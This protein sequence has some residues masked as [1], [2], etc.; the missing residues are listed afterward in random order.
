MCNTLK[1]RYSWGKLGNQ[2]TNSWYPTYPS[3]GYYP[4]SSGW[5]VGGKKPTYAT[6]PGLIST[7]LTWEKNRTWDIGIDWG[8]FNNRLTGTADYYNRRTIDMVGPAR[9]SPVC[10]AHRCPTS[11]TSR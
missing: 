7:S 9:N 5:L 11:T 1:L 3:M 10:S 6:A 4:D 2:N 8:L